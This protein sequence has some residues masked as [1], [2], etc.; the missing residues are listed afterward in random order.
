M[1]EEIAKLEM[2]LYMTRPGVEPYDS[3]DIIWFPPGFVNSPFWPPRA[4]ACA[5]DLL[6]SNHSGYFKN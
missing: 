1:F 3:G 6:N 4:C 5:A 2:E